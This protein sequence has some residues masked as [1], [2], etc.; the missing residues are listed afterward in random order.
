MTTDNEMIPVEVHCVRFDVLNKTPVVLLKDNEKQ[1]FMP[2]WIGMF[3]ATQIEIALEKV[4]VPRPMSHDL[5]KS[6]LDRFGLELK[7]AHI[8]DIIDSTFHAKLLMGRT[9]QEIVEVDA[10]PSDAIA[11]SLRT[12]TPILVAEHIIAGADINGKDP[13]DEEIQK[14]KEFLSNVKP[15][16]FKG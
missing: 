9:G 5:M 10:R 12:G 8:Y 16:D 2:I 4:H 13:D 3:E 6:I 14:F 1:R 7:E 15:G 11:L